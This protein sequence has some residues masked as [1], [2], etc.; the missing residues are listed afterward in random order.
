MKDAGP[1]L[2]CTGVQ[3]SC[4][5]DLTILHKCT[6]YAVQF[7]DVAAHRSLGFYLWFPV[8]DEQS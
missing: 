1:L 7:L 6:D 3:V 2:L 8:V 4:A 5:G